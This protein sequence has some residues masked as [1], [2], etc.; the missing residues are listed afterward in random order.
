[1]V[2]AEGL[3]KLNYLSLL[4]KVCTELESYLGFGDKVLAEFITELGSNCETVAEFHRKLKQNGADMPDYLVRTLLT[5]IYTILPERDGKS[6]ED[7]DGRKSKFPR[8]GIEDS[9]D[10]PLKKETGRFLGI[11]D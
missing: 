3:K 9:V 4:S 11:D 10:K 6:G 1:M 7:G 5:I 2:A 8:L